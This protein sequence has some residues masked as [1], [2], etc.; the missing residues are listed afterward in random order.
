MRATIKKLLIKVNG[1]PSGYLS[2]IDSGAGGKKYSF[3]YLP[4][5]GP[6]QALSLTMPV[7][8]PEQENDQNK[9]YVTDYLPP[10]LEMSQPEGLLKVHLTQSLSKTLYMDDMGL[11][12]VTGRSRIGNITAELPPDNTD[13][14]LAELDKWLLQQQQQQDVI[15]SGEITGVTDEELEPLFERLLQEYAVGSG[16]SGM[17]T[18]V[19]AKTMT[20]SKG[21]PGRTAF[22]MPGH[23]VKTSDSKYPYLPL[24]EDL[25]LK[26][27]AKA[28]LDVPGR[29]VSDNGEVLIIKRFD[30]KPGGG[31]YCL[32]D[33]C[34]MLGR[35]ADDK[36]SISMEKMTGTILL[37]VSGLNRL[38]T[39]RSLF[40]LAVVNALVRNSDAHAK[41]FAV[42]YDKPDKAKLSKV[43]DI[44]TTAAYALLRDDEP[45]MM[46]HSNKNWPMEKDLIRY[47]REQCQLENRECRAIIQKTI[48]AVTEV[49]KSIPAVIEQ[50]PGSEHVLSAMVHCWNDAIKSLH[51][52]KDKEKTAIKTDLDDVEASLVAS[53]GDPYR[54][55]K[56]RDERIKN[57]SA[58]QD[59]SVMYARSM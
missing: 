46:M 16:V 37:A 39:A 58:K 38:K 3:T 14:E 28:G 26:V 9:E 17:Q 2:T 1:K 10:A 25:C 36:Y 30:L 50:Y 56:D 7:P 49:G 34:T 42:I 15:D 4:E 8:Y 55:Q 24:N 33:G 5:A 59:A 43:F 53:Y 13:P 31:R 52:R 27:A 21:N 22:T 40:T 20:K 47:G 44:N 57:M 29:V 48:D 51:F 12:F 18:K 54:N 32:E 23:I 11:L 6:E 35:P 45:A 41:N 19:L